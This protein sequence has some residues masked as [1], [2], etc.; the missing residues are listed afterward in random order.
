M[1]YPRF[2]TAKLVNLRPH[3]HT[4]CTT[5]HLTAA[6]WRDDDDDVVQRRRFSRDFTWCLCTRVSSVCVRVS[7]VRQRGLCVCVRAFVHYFTAWLGDRK[8]CCFCKSYHNILKLYNFAVQSG[9]EEQQSS[10]KFSEIRSLC[11]GN[12]HNFRF[13]M[14]GLVVC[15]IG[16][17]RTCECVDAYVVLG[18]VV[19]RRPNVGKYSVRL[20][21]FTVCAVFRRMFLLDLNGDATVYWKGGSIAGLAGFC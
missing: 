12:F 5:K 11:T 18:C 6:E 15:A 13:W 4:Q 1:F 16:R 14:N 17:Q 10:S 19:V 8:N 21:L 2:V 3:S 7:F 20:D 9:V